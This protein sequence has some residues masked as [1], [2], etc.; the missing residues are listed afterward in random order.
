MGETGSHLGNPELHHVAIVVSDL[1]E[2]LAR[3]RRLGFA[4]DERFILPEQEVEVAT[5]RSGTGWIELIH[6][7]DPEGPIARYLAKRG[8]GMHHVAYA[9]ADLRLALQDLDAAGVRLIDAEP[10]IGAHGWRIAFIHPDSCGGVLTEL[11]QE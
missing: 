4:G 8:Q 11:V 5:F 1:D 2:A 9:V 6:P 3:Y 7:T 10:R